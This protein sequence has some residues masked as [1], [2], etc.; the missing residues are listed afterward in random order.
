MLADISSRTGKKTVVGTRSHVYKQPTQRSLFAELWNESTIILMTIDIH[1]AQLSRR[2]APWMPRD[3]ALLLF[4][5]SIGNSTMWAPGV[6]AACVSGVMP[7]MSRLE[8]EGDN[9]EATLNNNNDNQ[10][11]AKIKKTQSVCHSTED[12]GLRLSKTKTVFAGLPCK[13]THSP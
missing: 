9:A 8:G 4:R 5:R 1:G 10:K 13:M 7:V 12:S 2:A 11:D 3:C 6:Q